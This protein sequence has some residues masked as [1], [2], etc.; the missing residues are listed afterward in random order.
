MNYKISA[1][2]RVFFNVLLKNWC[3]KHFVINKSSICYTVILAFPVVC[4]ID[5]IMIITG[6]ILHSANDIPIVRPGILWYRKSL[7]RGSAPY[8]LL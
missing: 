2:S 8:I 7:Y 6:N 3:Q 5:F 1:T 4:D